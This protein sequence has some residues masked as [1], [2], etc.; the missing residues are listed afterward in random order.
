MTCSSTGRWRP[1][2]SNPSWT[3]SVGAAAA[4]STR[5]GQRCRRRRCRST[6]S[7]APCI[8]SLAAREPL[9]SFSKPISTPSS[10]NSANRSRRC[11][12]STPPRHRGLGGRQARRHRG[13]PVP[14]TCPGSAS[15]QGSAGR[16]L[17][18]QFKR[19]RRP[20]KRCPEREPSTPSGD[21]DVARSQEGASGQAGRHLGAARCKT[22]A[23][24]RCGDAPA[25]RPR[26][27]RRPRS[28]TRR[29]MPR[30]VSAGARLCLRRRPCRCD[31]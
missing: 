5:G 18:Q 10:T 24:L 13:Q 6:S 12:G 19:P 17:R 21:F 1:A 29:F 25:R 16:H 30:R 8:L 23:L 28:L 26:A 22:P 4:S 3:T 15:R 11:Q 20:P 27:E 9:G 31:S 14:L 2:V 7:T